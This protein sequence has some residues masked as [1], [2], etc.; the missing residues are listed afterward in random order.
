MVY[1]V[2][3][4]II[5]KPHSNP[6]HSHQPTNYHLQGRRL[7]ICVCH[8]LAAVSLFSIGSMTDGLAFN[9]C[10]WLIG[11]FAIASSFTSLFVYAS[12]LFP[13]ATRNGCIGICSMLAR[14][15]GAFTP[16]VTWMATIN[17]LLPTIFYG[18]ISTLAAALT[19]L[20]PE[21][22]NRELPDEPGQIPSPIT[23]KDSDGD[24]EAGQEGGGGAVSGK[25]KWRRR[26]GDRGK[27]AENIDGES[28]Q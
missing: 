10:M 3:L 19:L 6:L 23:S 7:F 22:M 16:A 2:V 17:P 15:V 26:W 28:A 12:E 21:T 25:G 1:R 18:V 4:F 11:K 5:S 13:T 20:L 8:L 27:K 24:E 14:V 9:L